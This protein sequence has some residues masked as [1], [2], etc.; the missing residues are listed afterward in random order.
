MTPL[1]TRDGDDGR[2]GILG[3]GRVPKYDLR[4]EVLGAIDEASATIGLAR[5][6]SRTPGLAPVLLQIQRDLYQMMAEAASLPEKAETFR[7]LDD[8][9]V[10]W[11][12]QQAEEAGK[13]VHLPDQFILSGDTP[14]GAA[15]DLARTVVRRSE[16]RLVELYHQG[17]LT[18]RDLLRYLNRL[19]SLLFVLE[20]LENQ[21]GGRP[22]PTP[23]KPQDQP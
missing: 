11:L 8:K 2:T 23:A 1:F 17:G 12:E 19:S 3:E 20:L 22:N 21:T 4:I 14:G 18:N 5:A 13:N 6:F 7:K 16:R 9:N 15:L 10:A